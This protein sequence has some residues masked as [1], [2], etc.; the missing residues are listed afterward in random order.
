MYQE[1][2]WGKGSGEGGVEE[3]QYGWHGSTG[4][5]NVIKK[6]WMRPRKV[7]SRNTG[8]WQTCSGKLLERLTHHNHNPCL[9]RRRKELWGKNTVSS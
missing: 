5:E 2:R 7:S 3:R 1:T 6:T 9:A 8:R 4:E